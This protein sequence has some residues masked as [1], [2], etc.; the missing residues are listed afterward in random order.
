MASNPTKEQFEKEQNKMEKEIEAMEFEL[1]I[2]LEMMVLLNI[3]I[4]KERNLQNEEDFGV[5]YDRFGEFFEN[6]MNGFIVTSLK[7][8]NIDAASLKSQVAQ[9]EKQ[10]EVMKFEIRIRREMVALLGT[11]EAS[12]EEL[13]NEED[14]A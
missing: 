6:A 14:V 13:D 8:K 1:K 12:R 3:L 10:R 7:K 4:R 11:V 9:M 5:M 2:R